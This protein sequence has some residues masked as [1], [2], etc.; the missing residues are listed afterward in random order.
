MTIGERILT[1]ISKSPGGNDCQLR[2]SAITIDTAL[3]LLYF[4]YPN[5]SALVSGKRVV[6]FGCGKGFQSIALVKKLDCS[7]IGIDTNRATL[8]K[9]IT[10]AKDHNISSQ[11]LSF[12]DRIST[13]M[14]KSFD[15]VI[16][17]NSFE[18][19]GNP[20]LILDE[21]SS[22]LK[23]SGIVLLTFGPPWFAPYGSHMEYFCKVPWINI[24]FS[25]KTVMKVRSNF[26]DDGAMR[27]EEVESGLNKMTIA[28][29][30][31]IV[32]LAN[33]KLQSKNYECVKGINWLSKLPLLRELFINHVSAVLCK[34]NVPLS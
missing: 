4:V 16:S 28:R 7:V 13:N 17:Q 8:E 23:D 10:N 30:E 5:L 1:T 25:E 24:L 12:V 2:D 31:N 6:D 22:L 9:A 14:F 3:D 20:K 26:R 34:A 33:L 32:S 18:H 19:F 15:V 27:Y 11:Q 29:F 21:M